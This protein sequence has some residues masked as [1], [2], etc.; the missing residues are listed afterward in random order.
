[1]V[2]FCV[3]DGSANNQKIIRELDDVIKEFKVRRE[4]INL[5]ISD[6]AFYMCRAGIVLKEIFP[7]L[8][9]FTCLAH[10]TLSGPIFGSLR[11]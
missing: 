4:D 9:H 2:K 6:A 1:M 3:I 7:N 5:L 8:Q 11:F 10:L